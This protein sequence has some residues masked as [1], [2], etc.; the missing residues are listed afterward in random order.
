MDTEEVVSEFHKFVRPTETPELSPFCLKFLHLEDKNLEEEET[1]PEVLQKFIYW[2]DEITKQF[3][4]EFYRP[5]IELDKGQKI[6]CVATWTDWDIGTQL[7]S[8]FSS[9]P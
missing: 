5:K 1:L 7:V 4:F 6:G 2:L 8:N 3:G 9:W